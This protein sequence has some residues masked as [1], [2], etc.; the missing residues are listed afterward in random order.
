VNV[1]S[2]ILF[3]LKFFGESKTSKRAIASLNPRTPL[4][5]KNPHSTE[6]T[7]AGKKLPSRKQSSKKMS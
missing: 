6:M 3:E 5:N 1:A 2:S 4:Q 7:F